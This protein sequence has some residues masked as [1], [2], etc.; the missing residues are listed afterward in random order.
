MSIDIPAKQV[1]VEYDETRV[2]LEQMKE[3]LAAEDYPVASTEPA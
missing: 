3:A 1:R 2:S